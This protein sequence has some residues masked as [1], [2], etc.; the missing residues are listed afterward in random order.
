MLLTVSTA[1]AIA[2]P[3]ATSV[4]PAPVP[5]PV[6]VP[7]RAPAPTS[8]SAPLHLI[9]MRFRTAVDGASS[10]HLPSLG[11]S[12][13][14]T[15][16]S[17]LSFLNGFS[18][19]FDAF[20]FVGSFLPL[21]LLLLFLCGLSCGL[22]CLFLFFLVLLVCLAFFLALLFLL[23]LL[24][25]FAAFVKARGRVLY[26]TAR[27]DDNV[28]DW[29]VGSTC[30]HSL[31]LAHDV[32]ASHDTTKDNV[33][34]VEMR[35]RL[36]RDEKLG[37]VG[38]RSRIRHAQHKRFVVLGNKVLVLE[39]GAVYALAARAVSS[40]EIPALRHEARNNPVE[41]A[42]L[43]VQGLALHAHALGARAKLE[44]VGGRLGNKVVEELYLHAAGSEG[45][46]LDVEED[47]SRTG[48]RTAP[49]NVSTTPPSPTSITTFLP[50]DSAPFSLIAEGRG[51]K[52]PL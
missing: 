27:L 47:L 30:L 37:A 20:S 5:V 39:L 18:R 36:E 32:L 15:I 13:D 10:P 16:T 22:G 28:I 7:F 23:A 44:E 52:F 41:F 4:V 6:P 43:Q 33:L 19:G 42:A 12:S 2:I 38:V 46:D 50:P 51:K 17:T 24:A 3:R 29:A 45:P 35:R 11:I 26:D 8:A 49:S 1:I 14:V 9:W 40:C 48:K 25:A 21:I 34:A 31:H